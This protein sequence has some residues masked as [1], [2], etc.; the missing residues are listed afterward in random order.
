MPPYYPG[1][2]IPQG[3]HMPPYYPGGVYLRVCICLPTTRVVY[4]PQ[5]VPQG[6]PIQVYTSGCTSVCVI[7]RFI[8]Q[9]VPGWVYTSGLY[10]R[11]YQGVP[12]WIL[13]RFIPQCVPRW[14]SSRVIPQGVLWWYPS[15]FIPK[16]VLRRVSLPGYSRFTVGGEFLLPW[17]FPF[18]CW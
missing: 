6:V 7:P 14:V 17:L 3:V 9:G 16:G 4:I 13:I 18:H 8:P 11:V 5:G 2:Y 12:G 15:W 1:V 10:L